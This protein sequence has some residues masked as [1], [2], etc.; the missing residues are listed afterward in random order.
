MVKPENIQ[1]FLYEQV[2]SLQPLPCK[3]LDDFGVFLQLFLAFS[4][5]SVLIIKKQLETPKRTWKVWFMDV[6]KQASSSS[7]AHFINLALSE[8]Y[9][10]DYMNQCNW[11]FILVLI[12][13][14]IGTFLNI[15]IFKQIEIFSY[16]FEKLY[17]VS[18]DYGTE[19]PWKNWLYQ[20]FLW[21]SMTG[22][23][24]IF[25]FIILYLNIEFFSFLTNWILIPFEISPKI[26]LMYIMVFVP[27]I[28]NGLSF[29]VTDLY[30]KNLRENIEE[31]RDSE[32]LIRNKESKL[33]KLMTT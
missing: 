23:I 6:S 28:L 1:S 12:D 8:K 19:N 2:Y 18:G 21:M 32:T 14:I 5:F 7:L 11:Y 15:M 31:E 29:W 33:R 25:L 27:S 17:F 3:L 20:T 4:S 10:L 30:L 9:T 24:K 16:D 22:I 26:E 13:V